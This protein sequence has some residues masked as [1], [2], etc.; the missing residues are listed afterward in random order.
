MFTSKRMKITD[1][2]SDFSTVLYNS[3]ALYVALLKFYCSE[4]FSLQGILKRT[5]HKWACA[6]ILRVNLK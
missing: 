4:K 3:T 6:H 1:H 2:G 5:S